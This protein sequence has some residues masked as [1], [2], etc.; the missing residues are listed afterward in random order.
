MT[1][2][3]ES[4]LDAPKENKTLPKLRFWPH[5]TETEKPVKPEGLLTYRTV[6]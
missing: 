6:R 3:V 1:P 5:N 4:P 2:E